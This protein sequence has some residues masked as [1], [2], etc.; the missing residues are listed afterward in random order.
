MRD[1]ARGLGPHGPRRRLPVPAIVSIVREHGGIR[2]IHTEPARD[3]Q[4]GASGWRNRYVFA[5]GVSR[6]VTPAE[7]SI[8]D[9]Y[10]LPSQAG[11]PKEVRCANDG[12]SWWGTRAEAKCGRTSDT[13]RCPGCGWVL[14]SA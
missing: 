6:V 13:F 7:E 5:N 8:L 11:V 12:C 1:R 3:T 14:G 9:H 2:Q 4:S 10:D